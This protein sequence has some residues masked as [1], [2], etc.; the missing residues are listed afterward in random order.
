MRNFIEK[1]QSIKHNNNN[2]WSFGA[3]AKAF[4]F[5]TIRMNYKNMISIPG[6]MLK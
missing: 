1:L 2:Y 3:F 4:V 5:L 6:K